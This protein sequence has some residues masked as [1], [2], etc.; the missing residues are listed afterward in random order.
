[1]LIE[2]VWVEIATTACVVQKHGTA[3]LTVAYSNGSPDASA[4][5]FAIRHTLPQTFPE[6]VTKTLWA[7]CK[8]GKVEIAAEDLT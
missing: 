2:N 6:V 3:N 5:E 1:M 8:T 7:K 4:E